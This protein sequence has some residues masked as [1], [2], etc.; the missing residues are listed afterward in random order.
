MGRDGQRYAGDL[1]EMRSG[2]IFA[3]GGG[4]ATQLINGLLDSNHNDLASY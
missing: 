4:Q 1:G 3:K 2:N